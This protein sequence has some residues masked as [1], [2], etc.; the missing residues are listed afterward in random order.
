MHQVIFY[1]VGN[2]D[3]SQIVLANGKRILMDFRHL[4]KAEDDSTPEIDLHARMRKELKDANKQSFDV[5]AFTHGDGDHIN[6]ST[7]F[8]ELRHSPKYQGAGRIPIPELWVP[9]AMLIDEVTKEDADKEFAI[10]RTEA[11]YRMKRGE[12]IR[13]FSRPDMLKT[14]LAANG[15]TVDDRRHLITDA[16]QIV[17]GFDLQR[18]GVE[19]FCHSPLVKHANEGDDLRNRCCLIFNVRFN[20]QG[21]NFDYLAIGDTTWDVFEDI[22]NATKA[23]KNLDRLKWDLFKAPHHCSYKALSD[24]KGEAETVPKPKVEEI[25][26][27]GQRGGYIIS[28]SHPIPDSAAARNQVEPPHV[29]ARRCY[30]RYLR[31]ANGTLLLVTMEEPNIRAPEPI[32]IAIESG[33]LVHKPS[34]RI[35]VLGIVSRSAPRAG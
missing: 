19:F 14:W 6:G 7:D 27:L 3:T 4:S 28:S 25:L 33:G 8:F 30:E 12:G 32:V 23:H 13:V 20:V 24:E 31:E 11:R 18:D 35:G 29:Q 10:W 34:S 16:G 15:L 2:G 21:N 9:A 17:P 5:V 22:V 26:K 1:P